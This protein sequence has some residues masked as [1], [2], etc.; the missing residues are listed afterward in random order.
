MFK[1]DTIETINPKLRTQMLLL[2][3]RVF[4]DKLGWN[5]PHCN[6]LEADIYDF[7]NSFYVNWLSDDAQTLLGSIRLI[8]MAHCNLLNTVFRDSVE[9]EKRSDIH[10]RK[11]IWEGTRLCIDERCFSAE[12]RPSSLITLLYGLFRSSQAMGIERLVCNCDSLMY[13]KYRQLGFDFQY[14]GATRAFAHGT[15]HC[16]VFDVSSQNLEILVSLRFQYGL[17]LTD[18]HNSV[19]G[20]GL[21]LARQFNRQS[22]D[23]FQDLNTNTPTMV[24]HRKTWETDDIPA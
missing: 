18:K 20:A 5:I 12:E 13:R 9:T 11:Q 24:S 15:V 8:S 10:E 2:R 22:N 3:K 1:V 19:D 17:G 7:T 21:A 16:L 14:L 23:V 6:G 4:C